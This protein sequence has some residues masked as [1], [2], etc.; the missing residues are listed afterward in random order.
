M[1]RER[2][3]GLTF[4]PGSTFAYL[5]EPV[6]VGCTLV[7]P[8]GNQPVGVDGYVVFADEAPQNDWAHPAAYVLVPIESSRAP[9]VLLRGGDFFP[10]L[11]VLGPN[12]DTLSVQWSQFR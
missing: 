1:L 10:K 7:L 2:I 3:R 4:A 8:Q 9:I 11:D 6:R 5:V 12:G